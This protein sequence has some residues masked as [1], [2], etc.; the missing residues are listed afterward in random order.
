MKMI[1][2]MRNR[3]TFSVATLLI[4]AFETI[5]LNLPQFQ[6]QICLE[7]LPKQFSVW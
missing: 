6:N 1:L 7:Q 5:F 3:D 2:I 4:D